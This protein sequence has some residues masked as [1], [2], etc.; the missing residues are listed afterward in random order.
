MRT[1]TVRPK[2]LLDHSYM[3]GSCG[4]I[5]AQYAVRTADPA[6]GEDVEMGPLVSA[7]HRQRV[8]GFLDRAK[9]E[10]GI[11]FLA[12]GNGRGGAGFF[13]EPTL[14]T[15]VVQD[16]E[17]VQREVFGPLVTVQHLGDHD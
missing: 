16:S 8:T 11:E 6:K 9:Q 10:P 13:V 7:D 15:G 5:S 14:V 4:S 2:G 17:I 3:H 12:G 1:N